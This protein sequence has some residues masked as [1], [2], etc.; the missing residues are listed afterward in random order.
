MKKFF[1]L[2][3]MCLFGASALAQQSLGDIAREERAKKRAGSPAVRLDDDTTHRSLTPEP[4][5]APST[6]TTTAAA[7]PP[8]DAKS[9]DDKSA[10]AKPADDKSADAKPADDKSADAKPADANPADAAKEKEAVKK[11]SGESKKQKNEELKKK[12]DAV[13]Q[14]IAILQRELDV[15]Q[16]EGRL[17]AA[18]YY[19]DAGTML[20]DQTKFAEDSRKEQA[21]IDA[22]KEALA[23][24]Q[25]KLADL[26]E[27]ARR[28][29]LPAS[30]TE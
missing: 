20:R 18:A 26:Q 12:I 15:A 7:A 13:K 25:Q 11:D 9:A 10:D 16:R 19:A 22:K 2:V 24:A 6:T 4:T 1:P 23:S 21:E 17:R 14:E 28:A 29:G 3:V 8:A 30:T 27:E 5:S